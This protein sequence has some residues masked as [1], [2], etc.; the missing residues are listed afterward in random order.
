MK[1]IFGVILIILVFLVG[2]IYNEFNG[3]P[4]SKCFAKRE[5]SKYISANYSDKDFEVISIGY[6]FKFHNY[7]ANIES[8]KENIKFVIDTKGDGKFYDEYYYSYSVEQK[9][10]RKFGEQL[11][12][13]LYEE[14]KGKVPDLK[15][16][17]TSFEIERGK[18]LFTDEYSKN[19]KEQPA[20]NIGFVGDQITKEEFVNKV[21]LV[22]EAVIKGGYK[23]K[24][25]NFNY[26]AQGDKGA[27]IYS[28]NLDESQLNLSKEEINNIK[29]GFDEGTKEELRKNAAKNKFLL[30]VYIIGILGFVI[31]TALFI[32]AIINKEKK[33]KNIESS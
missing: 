28:L 4:L 14:L 5:I 33:R 3:N 29:F 32:T 11:S 21:Y 27:L 25:F 17:A 30:K 13:I 8:K 6:N 10:A 22:K 2:F 9:I 16:V 31:G 20:I 19:I 18:Y 15:A 7:A 23:P 1:K 12:K 24:S 26:N